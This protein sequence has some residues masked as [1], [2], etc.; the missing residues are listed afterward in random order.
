VRYRIRRVDPIQVAKVMGILYALAGL[1]AAP[2]FYFASK[3]TPTTPEA[4]GFGLGPGF[5]IA[6]P[7]IYGVLG[8]IFTAIAAVIYNLIAGW[9]GG[10]VIELDA[11][12]QST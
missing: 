9:V 1:V 3:V 8:F 2:I 6:V 7:I 4:T 5:A 11:A 10:I 12:V